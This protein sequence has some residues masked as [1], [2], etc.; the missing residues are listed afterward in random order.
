MNVCRSHYG[1]NILTILPL[2][3]YS[4]KGTTILTLLLLGLIL[5]SERKYEYVDRLMDGWM[6]R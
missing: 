1:S 4:L 3:H 6:E 2:Q 5:P